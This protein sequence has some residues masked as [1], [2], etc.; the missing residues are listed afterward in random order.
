MKRLSLLAATAA[1]L[2]VAG[3]ALAAEDFSTPASQKDAIKGTMQ[4]DFG[5]RTNLASDGK[6]PAP[7]AADVY[8]TNLEVM[9]SVVFQGGNRR[10]PGLPTN[11]L[12]RPAQEGSLEYALKMVLRN[13]KTP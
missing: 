8:K 13:P 7:G 9:N 2:L 5:T 11:L 10:H 6:S 12:G 4:I 1:L 3:P